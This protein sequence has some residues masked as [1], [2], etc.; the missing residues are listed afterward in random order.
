MAV[1]ITLAKNATPYGVAL[2][3]AYVRITQVVID[4]SQKVM[5]FQASVWSDVEARQAGQQPVMQTPPMQIREQAQPAQ[6]RVLQ[7]PHTGQ[8]LLDE[9]G[10]P[11]FEEVAP[12]LPSF[13][14][15]EQLIGAAVAAGQDYRTVGYG[16]LKK[17]NL[18]KNNS[19]IDLI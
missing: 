17:L 1:Q 6:F 9:E 7:D 18:I 2:P 13:E 3:E 14:E 4:W 15:V 11:R 10:K 5:Q 16:V 19:P 12:A 8:N